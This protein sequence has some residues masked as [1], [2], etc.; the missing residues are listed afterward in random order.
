[1]IIYQLRMFTNWKS[2]TRSF[3]DQGSPSSQKNTT[4]I[5]STRTGNWRKILTTRRQSPSAEK[6]RFTSGNKLKL[7]VTAQLR[8]TW[9]SCT[10]ATLFNCFTSTKQMT[11]W[12]KDRDKVKPTSIDEWTSTKEN[13]GGNLSKDSKTSTLNWS[14]TTH[15]WFN[16]LPISVNTSILIRRRK[17]SLWRI[18]SLIRSSIKSQKILWPSARMTPQV[19]SF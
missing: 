13:A 7:K 17:N 10:P 5:P 18:L 15:S 14:H 11:S 2:G 3:W 8:F 9:A 4:S 19:M 6:K 12:L 1:M 16:S